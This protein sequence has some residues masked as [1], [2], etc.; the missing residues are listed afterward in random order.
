MKISLEQFLQETDQYDYY[1]LLRIRDE[2]IAGIHAYENKRKDTSDPCISEYSSDLVYLEKVCELINERFNEIVTSPSRLNNYIKGLHEAKKISIEDDYRFDRSVDALN[3]CFNKHYKA[4][5]QSGCFLN[6]EK[7]I[8]AWF[9]KMAVT[10]NGRSKA[11]SRTKAWVNI[12][13]DD[14]MT[15]MTHSDTESVSS[16]TEEPM[17]TFGKFP[18]EPY[19]YIGTFLLDLEITKPNELVYRRIASEVDLTPWR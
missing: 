16:Y 14:G 18:K 12:L 6:E 3:E 4:W 17:V 8:R 15:I 5:M 2:L 19:R 13:S 1:D 11:Q 7:T 9:P 10:E